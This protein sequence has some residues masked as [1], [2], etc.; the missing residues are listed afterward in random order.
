MSPSHALSTL[1]SDTNIVDFVEAK[2]RLRAHTS[3]TAGG[4]IQLPLALSSTADTQ[5]RNRVEQ[6]AAAELELQLVAASAVAEH[7]EDGVENSVSRAIETAVFAYGSSAVEA[8]GKLHAAGAFAP[9]VLGEAL[10][11]LGR[12]RHPDSRRSRFWFLTYALRDLDPSIK[13]SAALGLASLQNADAAPYLQREAE[14]T[15]IPMLRTRLRKLAEEL[16]DN[17]RETTGGVALT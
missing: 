15:D 10:L 17:H 11:W 16:Q 12:L 9:E 1:A 13:S 4:A 3:A 2:Q 5:N 8:L 7:F 14:A 6:N